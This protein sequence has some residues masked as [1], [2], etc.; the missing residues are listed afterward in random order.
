M[1]P[2]NYV[3]AYEWF[4]PDIGSVLTNTCNGTYYLTTCDPAQTNYSRYAYSI[5]S[6]FCNFYQQSS[7]PLTQPETG[8]WWLSGGLIAVTCFPTLTFNNGQTVSLGDVHG[9]LYMLKPHITRVDTSNGPYGTQLLTNGLP[10]YLL[11]L[12]G[13][14]MDFRVYI[15]K[16]FPGKFGITQLVNMSSETIVISP[17]WTSTGGSYYLDKAQEYY[18]TNLIQITNIAPNEESNQG[19][20]IYDTPGQTLGT[21]EADYTGYWKDY[22]RFTPDGSDSIA[23]TIGRIDWNWAATALATPHWHITSDP[24][25]VNGPSTNADDSFPTWTKSFPNGD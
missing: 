17:I 18:E 11:W 4:E 24:S 20:Q 23:V 8:A 7:W 3:N 25:G 13:G 2:G 6:P 10:P 14:P 22:V 19:S 21:I 16:T 1:L 9:N 15:S 12:D 5:D